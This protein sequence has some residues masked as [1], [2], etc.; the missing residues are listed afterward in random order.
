MLVLL[1]C[2][3]ADHEQKIKD[4][5]SLWEWKILPTGVPNGGRAKPAWCWL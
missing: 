4:R 2:R 3:L 5:R 1:N